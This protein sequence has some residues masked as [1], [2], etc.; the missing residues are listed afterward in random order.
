MAR[1]RPTDQGAV[2]RGTGRKPPKAAPPAVIEAAPVVC[3]PEPPT[4]LP[5][6]VHEAWQTCVAEMTANRQL[7]ES[8]LILL[9]AF[10]EAVYIHEEASAKVHEFGVLVAGRHGP[11]PNPMIKVQDNAARTIRL[12][13][14]NL[15]L[16][17]MSRIKAG[18]MEVIGASMVMDIRE[19]L[20]K[21]IVKS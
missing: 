21:E 6:L 10:V 16:N 2:K 9:K 17:P 1:G 8:D 19:R 3:G 20:V 14:D 18:I 13:S 7:R 12:L 15:G 4:G 5:P 11:V